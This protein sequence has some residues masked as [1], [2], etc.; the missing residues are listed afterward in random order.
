MSQSFDIKDF[1]P[2]LLN[3]AAE[4]SSTDFQNIYKSKYGMLRTEWRV[5]F[6]LARYGNLSAQKICE[7]SGLH[8]TKVSRAVKA[9]SDKRF[10]TR[11]KDS[12]DRRF[13]ILSLTTKGKNAYQ[14]LEK[15]AATFDQKLME[16]FDEQE[17]V[18]LT[19]SLKKLIEG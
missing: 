3:Q 8:K 5:M 9:L 16:N 10:I 15:Q 7:I 4:K 13:E 14:Y 11:T 1:L 2:Y 19:Q 6:H 17:R 12:Y 18:I